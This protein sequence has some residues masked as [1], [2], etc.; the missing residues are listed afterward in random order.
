MMNDV[1]TL[2]NVGGKTKQRNISLRL[3]NFNPLM[4]EVEV[5]N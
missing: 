5:V 4:F 2:L 1:A 3:G